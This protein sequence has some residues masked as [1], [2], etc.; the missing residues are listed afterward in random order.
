LLDCKWRRTALT[1]ADGSPVP[2]DWSLVDERLGG[3]ARI[4]RVNGGP[5]DGQWF[6]AVQVDAQGRP[7]NAGTGYCETGAEAKQAVEE[8][9]AGFTG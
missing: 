5:G 3:I 7:W 9:V 6:W 4:Y 2:D 1:R 8:I